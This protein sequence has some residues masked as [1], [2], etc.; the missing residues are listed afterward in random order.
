MKVNKICADCEYA[1]RETFEGPRGF[2]VG[3]ICQHTNA[4]DLVSGEQVPAGVAR[5]Q[6]IYC[7]PDGKYFKKRVED[8]KEGP[9]TVATESKI[10]SLERT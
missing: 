7:G 5:S 10:I 6:E 4:R 2:Q 9:A 8:V 3:Y 1:Q